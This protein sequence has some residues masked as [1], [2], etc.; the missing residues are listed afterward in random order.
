MYEMQMT[1]LYVYGLT[2]TIQEVI[3]QNYRYDV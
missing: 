3:D 2:K 1:N